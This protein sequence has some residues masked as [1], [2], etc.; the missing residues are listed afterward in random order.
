MRG[1][2]ASQRRPD[3][4]AGR[5]RQDQRTALLSSVS[6]LPPSS[7]HLVFLVGLWSGAQ[8]APSMA[9]AQEAPL[10]PDEPPQIDKRETTVLE[11][12]QPGYVAPGIPMGAFV[13][14]PSLTVSGGY[15]DNIFG[16]E[17]DR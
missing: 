2:A 15:D 11:R 17:H 12:E 13:L 4:A 5:H 14:S 3:R 10:L 6:R 8:L 16:T 9:H 1:A 7:V